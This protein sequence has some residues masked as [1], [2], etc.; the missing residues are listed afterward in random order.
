MCKWFHFQTWGE[1]RT[2]ERRNRGQDNIE[3]N[4]EEVRKFHLAQIIVKERAF[5][6]ADIKTNIAALPNL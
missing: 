1:E 2:T 6:E 5:Y 3:N 4:L